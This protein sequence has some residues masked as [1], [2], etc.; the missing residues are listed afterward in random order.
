MGRFPSSV[1]L[2]NLLIGIGLQCLPLLT[3]LTFVYVA[4]R[5]NRIHR[6]N[7]YGALGDEFH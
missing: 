1:T 5:H 4:S 2:S 3:A 7:G 6:A